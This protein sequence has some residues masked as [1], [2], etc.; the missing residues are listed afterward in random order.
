MKLDFY[1]Y[2]LPYIKRIQDEND[3]RQ[4]VYTPARRVSE[5]IIRR[6]V[7]Y[8][9]LRLFSCSCRRQIDRSKTKHYRHTRT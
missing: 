2:N 3:G 9:F 7:F 5:T 4:I 8:L 1:R 6:S